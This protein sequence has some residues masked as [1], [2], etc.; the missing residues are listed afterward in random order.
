MLALAGDDGGELEVNGLKMAIN[1]SAGVDRLVGASTGSLEGDLS[2]VIGLELEWKHAHSLDL[3]SSMSA[4]TVETLTPAT[5]P[6]MVATVAARWVMG[7]RMGNAA[8]VL[9]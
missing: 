8:G 6:A 2:R 5:W 1:G 4:K 3:K 9:T 7:I